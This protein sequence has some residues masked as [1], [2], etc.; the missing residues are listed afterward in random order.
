MAIMDP[1]GGE[2]KTHSYTTKDGTTHEVHTTKNGRREV[3]RYSE[4]TRKRGKVTKN[5]PAN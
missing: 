3:R 2:I 5:A 4:A 1:R